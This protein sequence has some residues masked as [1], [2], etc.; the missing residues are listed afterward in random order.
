MVTLIYTNTSK[1]AEVRSGSEALGHNFHLRQGG[2]LNHM[3]VDGGWIPCLGRSKAE[4]MS[5]FG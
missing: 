3:Q 2:A 1:A 4:K 5:T